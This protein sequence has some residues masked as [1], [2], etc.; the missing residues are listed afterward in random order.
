MSEEHLKRR[1]EAAEEYASCQSESYRKETGEMAMLGF[2]NGA[3]WAYAECAEIIGRL[4]KA[5]QY[6][7][8]HSVERK[9]Q[10][11]AQVALFD[12]KALR[13]TATTASPI[14]GVC[15]KITI[16][17][18]TKMDQDA[19]N[20]TPSPKPQAMPPEDILKFFNYSHLPPHLQAV[21]RPFYDLAHSIAGTM[22]SPNIG[23]CD[24][25]PR[26]PERTV[27][28]RK[29]LEAKDAAVRTLV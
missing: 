12:L 24:V 6:V 29:L 14:N 10:A 16:T 26:C 13:T 21:S 19:K 27:A 3:D 15:K 8:S 11:E 23:V 22:Q 20:E 28:L 5:L 9:M 4:E 1:N 18:E 25:L 7:E 2:M 17:K